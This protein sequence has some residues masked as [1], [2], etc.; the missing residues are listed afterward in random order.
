MSDVDTK[1]SEAAPAAAVTAPAGVDLRPSGGHADGSYGRALAAAREARGMSPS[2]VAAQLRLHVRQVL[3][4]EAEDLAAL[5]EG[6]LRAAFGGPDST[7]P[8]C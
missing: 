4:I 3:A 7:A 1:S 8:P 5:P 2:D 6:P